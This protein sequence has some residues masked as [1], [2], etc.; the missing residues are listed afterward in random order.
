MV[1]LPDTMVDLAPS[2]GNKKSGRMRTR[3]GGSQGTTSHGVPKLGQ[4]VRQIC[5]ELGLPDATMIMIMIKV[6]K[7]QVR[8]AIQLSSLKALN[9]DMIR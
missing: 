8:E 6:H 4:E 9:A 7:K 2:V 3:Q 5:V 1:D